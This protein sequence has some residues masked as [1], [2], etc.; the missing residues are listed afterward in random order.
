[1]KDE[2]LMNILLKAV[3]S[4]KSAAGG[5]EVGHQYAFRVL[6][7]A[8]KQEIGLAVE[9]MFN[10]KVQCVRVLNVEGKRKKFGAKGMG[11]RRNWRKAYVRLQQGYEINFGT[12]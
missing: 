3:I 2:R 10:V 9:K 11:K 8:N 5:S 1:M 7:D 6:Q 4:E 12:A